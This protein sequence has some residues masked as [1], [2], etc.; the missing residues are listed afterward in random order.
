VRGAREGARL[1]H[2][3]TRTLKENVSV[4]APYI[5]RLIS[6]YKT[7][8][9]ELEQYGHGLAEKPETIILTKTDTVDPA[10]VSLAIKEISKLN[11]DILTVS[12]LNDQSIKE[13]KD[14]IVRRLRG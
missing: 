12:V 5:D 3:S 4:G 2:E 6:N 9:A 1:E 7:I 8:R 13:V 10:A 14:E 11:K